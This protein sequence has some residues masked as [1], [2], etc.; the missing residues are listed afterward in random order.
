MASNQAPEGVCFPAGGD[1]E[2]STSATGRAIFADC[3]RDIDPELAARIEH[4]RDWR[5]GYLT[6][7]RDI[8]VSA[9]SSSAAALSVAEQG[10]SSAHRRFRMNRGGVERSI[11]ESMMVFT[12]P[13]FASVEVRGHAAREKDISIPYRGRRLFGSELRHQIDTWVRDGIAEPGFA[14]AMHAVLDNPDWLD[15]SDVDLAIL[16]A[17]AEMGPTRSLLR[18]GAR[19]HAVDLPR[20]A[21]WEKLIQTTRSTAG[22][23]RI[24]IALDSQGRPPFVVGGIVD[25]E[26]D[27]A[28]AQQ[29]GANLL[30]QAPE[31]RTWLHQTE[32]PFVLGTYAYADGAT[33]ALLS[34]ATDAIAEDLLKSRDDITLAYLATPTDV[35]MVPIEAVMESQRRWSSRGFAALF[36]A[37]LRMAGQFEPNY[38]EVHLTPE[39]R[40]V[41]INDS[42]IPQQGPNYALAKRIQRWRALHSRAQGVPVSLNLAP[43]TRTQSVIKNRALSAAYAGAGRF[44]VEIFEPA[45]STVLMAALLVH[46]LRNPTSVANPDTPLTNP[47]DQFTAVANHGGLWRT[48]YSPRSVLG[49][50]AL[51]GLL[52]SRS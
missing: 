45:T 36:Q 24:P 30:T 37:P 16:G 25:P 17:S 13:S 43:A 4:T 41:G 35:F 48:A 23:M 52:D 42:L 44:G 15:L 28:V 21:L 33:H 1:G 50:A 46:D 18:W 38:P 32:Q 31:I 34:I 39:G 20:P 51:M 40:E 7:L 26:D 8:I 9:T 47:M 3:V 22:S 14:S 29:A 49:I 27:S 6:P 19:V 5:S 11:G 12:S 10:L 2:R